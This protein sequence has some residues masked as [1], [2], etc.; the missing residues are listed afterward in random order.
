MW[1]KGKTLDVLI[2]ASSQ[3]KGDLVTKGVARIDGVMEGNLHA[4]FVIIGESG[5]IKG[6][7]QSRGLIVD[8]KIEGNVEA[9]DVAEITSRGEIMGDIR[10]ARLI[11]SEGGIFE[12]RSYMKA[13]REQ[14]RK[15]VVSIED[16][17][18]KKKE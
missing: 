11:V 18:P 5:T 17:M 14:D 13:L 16:R 10:T 4:D 2:G 7:V 3:L 12:G 9:S 1:K 15:D 8:G 6:N